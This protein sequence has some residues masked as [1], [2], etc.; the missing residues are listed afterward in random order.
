MLFASGLSICLFR[1]LRSL[2]SCL[3]LPCVICCTLE[4]RFSQSE[5]NL[6][7][8]L[9]GEGLLL[10]SRTKSMVGIVTRYVIVSGALTRY[11]TCHVGFMQWF[12]QSRFV[13][14]ARLL[15]WL[16][17]V[18]FEYEL[19]LANPSLDSSSLCQTI[20]FSLELRSCWRNVGYSV[21]LSYLYKS[22]GFLVYFNSYLAMLVRLCLVTAIL[23]Q[24]SRLN[25]RKSIRNSAAV[26]M[27]MSLWNS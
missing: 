9:S 17:Y 23:I 11:T 20:L 10:H 7:L 21:R 14:C 13:A 22:N 6:F 3:P 18:F 25:A 19:Y 2:I 4:R 15:D 16:Q 12:N 5:W 24:S 8:W 26:S 27:F 1:W